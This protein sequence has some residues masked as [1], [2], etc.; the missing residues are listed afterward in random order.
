[1]GNTNPPHRR[2]RRP[3]RVILSALLLVACGCAGGDYARHYRV[4][5]YLDAIRDDPVRLEAFVRDMPKG[6]DCHTHLS[7]VPDA[8]SYLRWAAEDGLCVRTADGALEPPPCGPG[9]LPAAELIRD[10][11]LYDRTVDRLSMRNVPAVP[12][13]YGHDHFF[14]VFNLFRAVS[15]ARR[16]DML[17]EAAAKAVRDNTDY[18]ELLLTLQSEPLGALADGAPWSGDLETEYRTLLPG[19][20]NLLAAGRAEVDAVLAGQRTILGC[21]GP[22]PPR[23]CAVSIRFVQQVN[24]TASPR[25][26]FASLIFGSELAARDSRV[27]GID[28]IGPEDNPAS[29]EHFA[30]HMQMLAF[31]RRAYPTLNVAVHAGELTPALA[32]PEHLTHHV[33]QAVRVVGARRIGHATSLLSEPAWEGLVAEMAR[34]R[35]GIAMLLG[36]NAQILGIEGSEHPFPVCL[37][38]GVPVM[39]ATDDQGVLR[40]SH[41]AEFMRAIAAYRL[42][43]DQ[44]KRLVRAGLEHAFLDGDPLWRT[45]GDPTRR[46]EACAADVPGRGRPSP[47][48]RLFLESSD[49]ARE[50]WRLEE[51]LSAFEDRWASSGDTP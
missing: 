36:S 39:L 24:R 3:I 43:W 14:A 12:P 1:M 47:A 38:R 18:L 6:A 17:A 16:S 48:C 50:Q 31:A 49:R 10:E 22:H 20:R 19:V 27:V 45:P 7:G 41:T 23:A 13:R 42:N 29:L 30:L 44:L 32:G 8:E 2:K 21:D 11:A 46:V 9:L 28:L 26:T 35:I 25:R 37:E 4:E 40:S 34:R 5:R 51:R 33:T 15:G